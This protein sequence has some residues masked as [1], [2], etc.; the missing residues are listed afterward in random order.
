[1]TNHRIKFVRSSN[2]STLEQEVNDW[3]KEEKRVNIR[4]MRLYTDIA[5]H[6]MVFMIWYDYTDTYTKEADKTGEKEIQDELEKEAAKI[7]S[8]RI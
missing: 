8:A 7:S 2:L 1:M 5:G 3:L 6:E 4:Q